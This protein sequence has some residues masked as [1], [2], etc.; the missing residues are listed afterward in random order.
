MWRALFARASIDIV[1]RFAEAGIDHTLGNQG[2]TVHGVVLLHKHQNVEV[3]SSHLN[4]LKA[5]A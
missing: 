5:I 1:H 2:V 3:A 4:R